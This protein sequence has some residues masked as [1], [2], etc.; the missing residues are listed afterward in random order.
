[1]AEEKTLGVEDDEGRAGLVVG[2]AEAAF[3]IDAHDAGDDD[4]AFFKRGVACLG[5]VG[6]E[7][8]EGR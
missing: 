2:E 6:G 7:G 1:V 4:G 8:G 5:E 3:A